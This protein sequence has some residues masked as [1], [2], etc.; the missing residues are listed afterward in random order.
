M[1]TIGD[2]GSVAD[3]AGD[4]P[5]EVVDLDGTVVDVVPRRIM[6]AR[7]LRHRCTY[8]VV[9]AESATGAEP[10]TRLGAVDRI[11]VHR[12]AGWKDTYPLFWDLAFGGVC[13]IGEDWDSAARRELAEEAGIDGVDL[14]DLGPVRYQDRSNSVLGRVYLAWWAG[15]IDC[16]DGEV[17]DLD[18]VEL[19]AL[20]GWIATNDVCPDSATVVPPLLGLTGS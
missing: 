18:T 7:N 12:R 5:V 20:A 10:A 1:S 2:P 15:P 17:I 14:H 11:V 13:S 9:V 19:G 8:V 16:R 4:E 3:G 6:R